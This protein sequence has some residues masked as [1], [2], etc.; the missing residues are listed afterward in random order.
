MA[1]AASRMPLTRLGD[2][3]AGAG[4]R[5]RRRPGRWSDE[6]PRAPLDAAL[7]FAPVG[8]LVLAALRAVRRAARWV[9]GIHELTIPS[10][11]RLAVGR[12]AHRPVANLTRADGDA[13]MAVAALAS[14][15]ACTPRATALADANRALADLREGRVSGAAVLAALNGSSWRANAGSCGAWSTPHCLGF[16]AAAALVLMLARAGMVWMLARASG[17]AWSLGRGARP[18]HGLLF[19]FWLHAA[20]LRRLPLHRRAEV[21]ARAGAGCGAA[22]PVALQLLGWLLFLP[23]AHLQPLLAVFGLTLAALAW[24]ALVHRFTAL[25][26]RLAGAGA[27]RICAPSPRR[28]GWRWRA[29]CRGV[30]AL[31]RPDD[32][33]RAAP[34]LGLWGFVAPVFMAA[35]HRMLPGVRRRGGTTPR[36][37]PPALAAR[38]AGAAGACCSGPSRSPSCG[39][40]PPAWRALQIV[41]DGAAALLVFAPRWLRRCACGAARAAAD[42]DA[43][44]WRA[45]AGRGLRAGRAL[46]GAA[47][48]E[49]RPADARPGRSM[50]SR[51]AC[52]RDA[53]MVT[54]VAS[55]QAGRAPSPPT[56]R[57]GRCSSAPQLAVLLRVAAALA[58][59]AR[60]AAGGRRWPSRWRCCLGPAGCSAG[61]PRAPPLSHVDR[62]GGQVRLAVPPMLTTSEARC[63]AWPASVP[64]EKSRP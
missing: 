8:A 23:G 55:G 54:R 60:P 32:L 48:D 64:N 61:S 39:G 59:E 30:G 34:W 10:P 51:W 37:A 38:H 13:F 35:L 14:R 4:A 49:R 44:G 46:A 62:L 47:V 42:R 2:A 40:L 22:L 11:L 41:L 33:V 5:A 50:P 45:V 25:L 16:S 57:P 29:A 43:A 63:V 9:R 58:D 53:G 17:M 36:G 26:R 28:R 21:A 31:R 7:I 20:F 6:A 12:A 24:F 15:C 56:R 27:H 1:Q 52:H 18:V 3:A 19:G